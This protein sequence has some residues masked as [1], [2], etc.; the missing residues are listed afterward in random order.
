MDRPWRSHKKNHFGCNIQH[1]IWKRGNGYFT[2][3]F[4]KV[5]WMKC[6]KKYTKIDL[7]ICSLPT[8]SA[9]LPFGLAIFPSKNFI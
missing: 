8:S 3:F 5:G 2:E 9:N 6:S 7:N 4:N 1:W